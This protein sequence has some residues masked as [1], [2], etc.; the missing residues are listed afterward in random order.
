[1]DLYRQAIGYATEELQTLLSYQKPQGNAD[2]W[3]D[4]W[5]YTEVQ[6]IW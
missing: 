3:W 4:Y 5:V 1:M 6:V 2:D